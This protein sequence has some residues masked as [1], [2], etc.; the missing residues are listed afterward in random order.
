MKKNTSDTSAKIA[1]I[2]LGVGGIIS[3]GHLFLTI[4]SGYFIGKDFDFEKTGQFGDYV[5]GVIGTIFSLAG[6]ILVYASFINQQS[7]NTIESFE[8]AY[9]EMLRVHEDI[10]KDMNYKGKT[11]RAVFPEILLELRQ[12]YNFV[13]N[14]LEN[15]KERTR[16]HLIQNPN[17][18][19]EELYNYLNKEMDIPHMATAMS[20]G[21]LY[22][23]VDDYF[24]TSK[25]DTP[26]SLVNELVKSK[27]K[28]LDITPIG[29]VLGHY[30]RQMYQ[31]V[32]YVANTEW[33]TE[34]KKYDYVTLVSTKNGRV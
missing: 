5:G 3:I 15:I 31:I 6:T 4:C 29:N 19:D 33:L 32:K 27:L 22:Y 16:L 9:F 23:G 7:R 30:Y 1:W 24:L 10:I 13:F 25:K 17:V 34:K 11:S 2:L 20:V 21:Y 18:T 8:L 28:N 26:L 14:S 12:I